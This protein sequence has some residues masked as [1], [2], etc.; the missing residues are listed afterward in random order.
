MVSARARGRHRSRPAPAVGALLQAGAPIHGELARL[1]E[2]EPPMKP[3][4][5]LAVAAL[6]AAEVGLASPDGDPLQSAACRNAISVLEDKESEVLGEVPPRDPARQRDA[7]TAL[8]PLRAQ[9]ARVCLGARLDAEPP[10][11]RAAPGPVAVPPVALPAAHVPRTAS[12]SPPPPASTRPG[13][14]APPATL[15]ACDAAGCWAS[16]GTRLQRLGP[17]LL[18]PGGLCT[19]QGTLV[20]CP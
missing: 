7:V 11:P 10:P 9:A 17:G 19:V 18:G 4:C 20:N 2:L 8:K 15:T 3:H 14:V 6:F 1:G 16:D 5:A 12:P 13:P